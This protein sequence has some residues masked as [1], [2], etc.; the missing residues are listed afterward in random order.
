MMSVR[1]KL[2][3]PWIWYVNLL[4]QLFDP[5]PLIAFNFDYQ[6]DDGPVV[7]LATTDPDKAAALDKL[8][9]EVKTFGNVKLSIM[10]DS[11]TISNRAFPR[12]KELFETAFKGNP[13][14]KG[15]ISPCDDG[16]YYFD[17][18]YVL[19]KKAVVQF[20]NDNLNDAHGIVSTLYQ[21]IAS[22][23]FEEA[24]LPGVYYCTDTSDDALGKPL[25]EWP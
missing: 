5:D 8:L 16:Y 14:F 10:I 23:V 21:D 25:G 12:A 1:T 20:F 3:P 19:F 2:S 24:N 22:I 17:F 6:G 4:E 15:A 9:P 13:I 11:P 7:T 18:T